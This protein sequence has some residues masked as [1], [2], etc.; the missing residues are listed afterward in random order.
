MRL[1]EADDLDS[2]APRR[3]DRR[4]E[5]EHEADGDDLP[6]QQHALGDAL[7]D[8]TAEGDPL[9]KSRS[10]APR[11]EWLVDADAA[12]GL[13][14][15]PFDISLSA[16]GKLLEVDQLDPLGPDEELGAGEE[17]VHTDGGEEGPL[18]DD[19]ELREEDLPALDA[20][21]DGDVADD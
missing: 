18:D 10:R 15:G 12:G 4:G 9:R 11:P 21:D 13:D 8:A 1:P 19:E 6:E 2:A 5:E 16:E 17:V 7:D 14:V 3:R 20:D